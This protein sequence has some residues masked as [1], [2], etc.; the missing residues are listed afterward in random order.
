MHRSALARKGA[1]GACEACGADAW[2][3]SDRLL[4]MQALEPT[5]GLVPGQGVEV[6]SV[7]CKNCGLMRLHAATLLLRD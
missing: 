4:L 2:G 3:L 1:D 7:F 5:G 6:V